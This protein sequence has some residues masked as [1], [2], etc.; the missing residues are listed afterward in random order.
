[1]IVNVQDAEKSLPTLL[2]A[3]LRGQEV[4]I[5]QAGKPLVR[6]QPLSGLK[7]KPGRFKGEIE[8][9]DFLAHLEEEELQS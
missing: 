8:M 2:N 4:V 5:A 3:A 7:G 1:M 9:D 6:L